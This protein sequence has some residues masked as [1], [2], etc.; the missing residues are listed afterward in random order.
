MGI[1]GKANE[2]RLDSSRRDSEG[3]GKGGMSSSSLIQ[4][5]MTCIVLSRWSMSS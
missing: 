4:M 3:E 2:D 5:Q 1:A